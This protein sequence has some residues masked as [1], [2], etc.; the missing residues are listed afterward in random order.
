[1]MKDKECMFLDCPSGVF[2]SSDGYILVSY[3]MHHDNSK[4]LY[5]CL[6][7][8]TSSECRSRSPTLGMEVTIQSVEL[9]VQSS[10]I[11]SA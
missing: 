2:F 11:A 3:F 6:Q 10:D 7:D 4:H 1:M 8:C 9:V 5:A